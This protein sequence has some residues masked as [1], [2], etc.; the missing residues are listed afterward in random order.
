MTT[1]V[2]YKNLYFFKF[3][4]NMMNFLGLRVAGGFK[5]IRGFKARPAISPASRPVPLKTAVQRVVEANPERLKHEEKRKTATSTQRKSSPIE[6]PK[7]RSGG[8]VGGQAPTKNATTVGNDTTVSMGPVYLKGPQKNTIISHTE[9]DTSSPPPP[10][11]ISYEVGQTGSSKRLDEYKKMYKGSTFQLPTPTLT[12]GGAHSHDNRDSKFRPSTMCG[13][14]RKNVVWPY[15]L[16]DYFSTNADQLTSKTSCFNR[17]QIESLLHEMWQ[18]VGISD[19]DLKGF[20]QD[21]E[22]TIGGDVRVD[23]PLD[24]IQCEYKY[25]NN[26]IAM[27]IDLS[28]YIC[29]P[30]RDMVAAHNPMADWFN[31]GTADPDSDS[32]LMFPDYYYEPVLTAA[33]D[34]MFV[35]SSGTLSSI[36]IMAEKGSILTA[37]TEV[38]PEATPQGFSAKFRKNWDVMHVQHFELQPQQE[39]IV[40]FTVKLSKVLDLKQMLAFTGSADKFEIFKELSMFPMVTFQGQ[41]TTAVSSKLMRTSTSDMNRFLDTTAPR[42]SAS[43]LSSSMTTKARVHTKTSPMRRPTGTPDYEYTLGDMLD[44]FS[45]SKRQL[46]PYDSNERGQQCPYYQVNDNLGFFCDKDDNP[47]SNYYLSQLTKVKLKSFEGTLPN[48]VEVTSTNLES[49]DTNSNWA[50]IE[51]KTISRASLEKTSA[52]ISK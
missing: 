34:V 6:S 26:N 44:V 28:L 18:G 32:M 35:N 43:M 24:S 23:F 50:K 48:N 47:T 4:L 2:P 3:K 16:H 20:I 19:L 12:V 25:F 8:R 51:S 33:Q 42:S 17:Y 45:I 29:M 13:F 37:S 5:N 15:W 41:D 22:N 38:V 52:D 21:L 36:S 49:I 40:T 10:M 46:M 27:P 39:L 9:Y 31:P 11:R 14:G 1:A 30:A 7:P